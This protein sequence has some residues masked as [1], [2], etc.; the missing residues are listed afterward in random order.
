[1]RDGISDFAADGDSAKQ[2]AKSGLP[3]RATIASD[4]DDA[5]SDP[6]PQ[7][8]PLKTLL[9][10]GMPLESFEEGNSVGDAAVP[11]RPA[12]LVQPV[13][14]RDVRQSVGENPNSHRAKRGFPP[15]NRLRR[16]GRG[17]C[18]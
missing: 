3:P 5:E 4:Q 11:P 15:A 7:D 12:V 9:P 13:A 8:T 1:M 16:A 2:T 18:R 14:P 6:Q 10:L 17:P